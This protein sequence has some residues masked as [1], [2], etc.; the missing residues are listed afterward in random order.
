[1]SKAY[2]LELNKEISSGW[3]IASKSKLGLSVI[4]FY[5]LNLNCQATMEF[6]GSM[7]LSSAQFR[8]II[9]AASREMLLR[10]GSWSMAL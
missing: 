3:N 4:H 6:L 1:M 5:Q 9:A 7:A 10:D 8:L 2:S